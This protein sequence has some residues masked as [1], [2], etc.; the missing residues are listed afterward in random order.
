MANPRHIDGVPLLRNGLP[1][2]SDDCCCNPSCWPNIC[3][4]DPRALCC[5]YFCAAE[6]ACKRI[7]SFEI[8]ISGVTAVPTCPSTGPDCCYA[9]DC[10]CDLFNATFIHEHAANC[11]TLRRCFS[12]WD[13][14]PPYYNGTGASDNCNIPSNFTCG[15]WN[16]ARTVSIETAFANALVS[17]SAGAIANLIL[18]NAYT[19]YGSWFLLNDFDLRPGH[20]ITVVMSHSLVLPFSAEGW[21]SQKLFLYDFANGV[22]LFESCPDSQHYPVDNW[23]GGDAILFGSRR[24]RVAPTGN[25]FTYDEN[26][27]PYTCQ[28]A[29]ATVTV[30]PPDYDLCTESE[31]PPPL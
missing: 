26:D 27:W 15:F 1:A 23:I 29:G 22:K 18:P 30:E 16:S 31:E 6:N 13:L 5:Q 25:T 7:N 4:S 9:F 2:L 17:Y 20:Y 12:T 3:V 8:N 11:S 10:E 19:S 28:L 21:V 14:R 24:W